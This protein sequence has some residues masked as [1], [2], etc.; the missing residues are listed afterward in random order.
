M[1]SNDLYKSYA[2]KPKLLAMSNFSVK[3]SVLIKPTYFIN[4]SDSGNFSILFNSPVN[5]TK[6][7]I[8]KFHNN[9][10]KIK[11]PER[12]VNSQIDQLS[13]SG[14]KIHLKNQQSYDFNDR[15][16]FIH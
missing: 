14:T 13:K 12:N 8:N 5:K 15:V 9:I 4:N 10:P 1:K 16:Y 7:F 3:G 6:S 2:N 11:A